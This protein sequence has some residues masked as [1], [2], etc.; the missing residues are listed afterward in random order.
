MKRGCWFWK[1]SSGSAVWF[2]AIFMFVI[3]GLLAFVFDLAHVM[4]VQTEL[5][6][7]ADAAALAGARA[8]MPLTGE[9]EPPW[10]MED[11]PTCAAAIQAALDTSVLNY[12]DAGPKQ[13][14]IHL[15]PTEV[16]TGV[17]DFEARTF[18]P[19]ACNSSTNAVKVTTR[20]SG[21]LPQGPVDMTI[22]RIFGVNTMTPSATAIAAVGYLET[23]PGDS[24]GG[25]L[26][27]DHD[28]L[29]KAWDYS[30]QGKDDK[31]FYLVFGPALG[32]TSYEYADNGSWALPSGEYDSFNPTIADYIANGTTNDVSVTD[33]V[34]LKNGQM[35]NLVKNLQDAIAAAGGALDSAVY[36]VYEDAADAS[37]GDMWNEKSTEVR[38][39]WEVQLTDAWKSTEIKD[40]PRAQ[41]I[42]DQMYPDL[43]D[44][45]QIVGLIEFRLTE[46]VAHAGNPG[47]GPPSNTYG[48]LVKL[49]Q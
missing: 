44:Q 13:K 38:S 27:M 33:Y 3:A 18:T 24:L 40:E 8:L 7:A 5:S 25:F 14:S 42:I 2:V 35:A 30:N 6:N 19:S 46:K 20:A 15:D 22:A 10:P 36:G 17:W 37:I 11:P 29:Q 39:F 4:T 45:K 48:F 26:A 41:E 43:N 23:L 12:I 21:D 32:Q 16:I 34:D 49:V 9:G 31:L 1:D 28:Y 47:N